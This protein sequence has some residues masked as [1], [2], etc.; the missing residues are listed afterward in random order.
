MK[1]VYLQAHDFCWSNGRAISLETVS[2]SS[3]S[4]NLKENEL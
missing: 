3:P 1:L 2:I 4:G